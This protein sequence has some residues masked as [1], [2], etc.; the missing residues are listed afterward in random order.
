MIKNIILFL[1]T[2]FFWYNIAAA[3]VVVVVLGFA[4]LS[5][6]KIYTHHNETVE[7]PNLTGLF[8]NEAEIVLNENGLNST[9]IVTDS[10]FDYKDNTKIGTIIEQIPKAGTVVKKE[11]KFYY[12]FVAAERPVFVPDLINEN[13]R[14][15]LIKL[16]NLKFKVLVDSVL[17]EED[18]VVLDIKY[19]GVSAVGQEISRGADLLLV[20]GV[21]EMY[22]EGEMIVMPKLTD[23]NAVE[24][25]QRINDS[26]L[27]V[28]S[29]IYD[30]GEP[31]END[32]KNFKVYR[33]EPAEGERVVPK[34][35]VNLWL[36]KK[37]ADDDDFG[38]H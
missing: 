32:K 2:N 37:T 14:S 25:E 1:K 28:N 19:Q 11:R 29:L 5:F 31:S 36:S 21:G 34:K 10:V 6:L 30:T 13:G 12:L 15:A 24:A 18:N 17:S 38:L 16:K 26:E 22:G 20:V 4:V 23:L 33:Q 7:M 8:A 9:D 35:R 3:V 27:T